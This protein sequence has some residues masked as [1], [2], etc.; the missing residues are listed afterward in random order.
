VEAASR[1]ASFLIRY[2]MPSQ[3]PEGSFQP[4][5][6]LNSGWNGVLIGALYDPHRTP[7]FFRDTL[8][9]S[10]LPTLDSCE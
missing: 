10:P 2:V 8:P 6:Q 4:E 7:K 5:K 9:A 3:N 1:A